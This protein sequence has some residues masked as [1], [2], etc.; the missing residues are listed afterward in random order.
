MECYFREYLSLKRDA[1]VIRGDTTARLMDLY[2]NVSDWT[3]VALIADSGTRAVYA[4]GD[5]CDANGEPPTLKVCSPINAEKD[6]NAVPDASSSHSISANDLVGRSIA[7]GDSN[8]RDGG[9]VID[10]LVNTHAWHLGYFIVENG[11]Y[12]VL[13]DAAWSTGLTMNSHDIR[14]EGIHAGALRSAPRYDG[15]ST[16]TPGVLDVVYRHYTRRD[17]LTG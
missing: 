3:V 16:L 11:E 4:P 2:F 7:S 17:F 1:V 9:N 6:V 13:L 10:L 5:I 12:V 8:D 14:I 15:L